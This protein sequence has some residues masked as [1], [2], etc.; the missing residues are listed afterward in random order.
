MNTSKTNE[1]LNKIDDNTN[2]LETNTSSLPTYLPLID[3]NTSDTSSLCN[4]INTKLNAFDVLIAKNDFMISDLGRI[5]DD[6]ENINSLLTTIDATL[7]TN[8]SLLADIK[9]N[10]NSGNSIISELQT[11]GDVLDNIKLDTTSLVNDISTIQSDISASSEY[12]K[13]SYYALLRK[14][15]GFSS[16][17]K[18]DYTSTP[19]YVFN[20]NT[21]GQNQYIKKIIIWLRT[22]N[23]MN[24]WTIQSL[25]DC[26]D[27]NGLLRI[28]ISTSNSA[29]DTE[30]FNFDNNVNMTSFFKQTN[31]YSTETTYVWEINDINIPIPNNEY[32]IAEATWNSDALS[33][34]TS[35]SLGCVY[36]E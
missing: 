23:A 25:F 29:I 36:E 33:G 27:T 15:N 26:S 17:T 24:T 30:L 5:E 3:E 8:A 18:K 19:E 10:T 1:L 13:T 11:Q 28:G 31:E 6:I 32:I 12:N 4:S 21:S 22:A 9:T 20:Q 14:T 7:L 34:H 2:S 35:V 16:L